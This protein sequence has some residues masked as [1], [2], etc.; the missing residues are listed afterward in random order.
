M[1]HET[2]MM[3]EIAES[4]I[5]EAEEALGRPLGGDERD[6][7][8]DSLFD[9]DAHPG[10]YAMPRLMV[11]RCPNCG[12]FAYQDDPIKGGIFQGYALCSRCGRG[13]S[14]LGRTPTKASYAMQVAA[15]RYSKDAHGHE[16]KGKGEG[17]G[18]FTSGGGNRGSSP[19]A[20]YASQVKTK[21]NSRKTAASLPS[22]STPIGSLQKKVG[23][24]MWDKISKAAQKADMSTDA[25]WLKVTKAAGR[26]GWT[27]AKI[28]AGLLTPATNNDS[29]ATRLWD[30][31]VGKGEWAPKKKSYARLVRYWRTRR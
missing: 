11:Y 21:V 4:L 28:V 7:I 1:K 14:I 9:D 24:E 6:E 17:G 5:D 26:T 8:I 18:Q 29:W 19:I 13:F 31:V 3:R 23:K 15:T 20:S 25:L 27:T 16:H 2:N 30:A 10:R 12:G 22:G